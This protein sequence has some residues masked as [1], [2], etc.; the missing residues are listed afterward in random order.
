MIEPNVGDFFVVETTGILA[1]CIQ[2]GTWSKK[3]HAGLYIGNNQIIEATASGVRISP[4]H[5]YHTY[6]IKWSTGIEPAWTEAEG[7]ML[8]EFAKTFVGQAYG[9][10]S[11]I[12]CGSK[13]LGISLFPAIR[14]AENE[15]QVICSQ[16]VAWVWSHG[17]RKL[18][19]KQHAL[20]TPKDLDQVLSRKGTIGLNNV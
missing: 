8:V 16:L 19:V 1:R 14:R 2:L 18:S 4:L 10:W 20:V 13:C 9:W 15:R 12:A 6:N 17:H 7:K 5:K 3:N 11:I